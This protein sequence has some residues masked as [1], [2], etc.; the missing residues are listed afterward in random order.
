M[1]PGSLCSKGTHSLMA[2]LWEADSVSSTLLGSSCPS[3]LFLIPTKLTASLG[4][5]MVD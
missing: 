4:R 2:E 1:E 3:P 5:E